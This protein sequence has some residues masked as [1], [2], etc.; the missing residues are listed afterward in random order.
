MKKFLVILLCILIA[1]PLVLGVILAVSYAGVTQAAVPTVEITAQEQTVP[2]DGYAWHLPVMGGILSKTFEAAQ[3]GN[4]IELGEL[5]EPTLPLTLPEGYQTT[6]VLQKDSIPLWQGKGEEWAAYTLP[7]DGQYTMD[8]TSETSYTQ[9]AF[10]YGWFSF[11]ISFSLVTPIPDPELLTSPSDVYQGDAFAVKITNPTEGVVPSATTDLAITEFLKLD[12]GSYA[13]YLPMSYST[14]TGAHAL[15]ITLG[16]QTWE[17]SIN[18]LKTD[19]PRQDLTIDTSDPGV[20]AASTTQAYQQF[21][22]KMDSLYR[23]IDDTQYWQG[24]F[25]Q[26]AEGRISTQYAT[27]R[28]TNGALTSKPHAGMDFAAPAGSPVIAAA[29]GRIVFADFL[30]T[31]G[32][33]IVIEHGG[34]LKSLY[35]HMSALS[36]GEGDIVEQG[37]QIGQVGSTGYSTGAHLHFEV[38]VGSKTMNPELLINGKGNLL[39]FYQ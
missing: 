6:L 2:P 18:V 36:V 14:E 25:I 35:F 11:R 20:A 1:V 3:S 28:Y 15:A 8:I 7:G 39:Y 16:E 23:I 32:W 5:Q 31:S 9:N 13:A 10:A 22:S 24:T 4:A 30:D 21:N 17:L 19:F 29:A 34:G 38:R 27:S 12:D 33:T 26:P 37:Q